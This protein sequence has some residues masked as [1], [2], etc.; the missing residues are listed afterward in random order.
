MV[1]LSIFCPGRSVVYLGIHQR[2]PA[3]A[4]ISI[5]S[6]FSFAEYASFYL[7][8]PLS[9]D[10]VQQELAERTSRNLPPPLQFLHTSTSSMWVTSLDGPLSFHLLPACRGNSGLT[11]SCHGTRASGS[12]G[13]RQTRACSLKDWLIEDAGFG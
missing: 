3:V 1:D 11:Q 10:T 5:A 8:P 9:D 12:T 6:Y 7:P 13:C 4:E 2:Q